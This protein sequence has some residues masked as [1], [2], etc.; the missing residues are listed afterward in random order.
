MKKINFASDNYAGVHPTILQ[1]LNAANEGDCAAYGN[2][3]WTL[4]AIEKFKEH[5][6]SSSEVFFVSTGTA[7]NVLGLSTYLSSYQAVIAAETSHISS[8]ECGAFENYTGSKI[9]PVKTGTGKLTVDL[10]ASC[11][12]DKGNVHRVQPAV[13]SLSQPTELGTLYSLTELKEITAYAHQNGLSVHMDG[14]RLCNAAAALNVSLGSVTRECGIDV[15]SFGGTKNGMLGGEAVVFFDT[16]REL[17]FNFIR[18]QGMQLSSKMRFVSAQFTAL[19]S[20]DLWL[21]NALHANALAHLLKEQLEPVQE[22][23]LAYPTQTNALFARIDNEI[24]IKNLLDTYAFYIWD[25]DGMEVRWMTSFSTTH[26][27]VLDFSQEI[28]KQIVLFNKSF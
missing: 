17:P 11:L 10:I 15:L 9:I 16:S 28:K 6:G 7:A 25:H 12:T 26:E 2:D 22:I 1:A 13:V 18:K 23:S 27:Q 4:E 14:A 21:K 5:F 8:D 20:N 19:L 24:V 3:R